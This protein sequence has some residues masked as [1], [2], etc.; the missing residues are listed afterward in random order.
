MMRTYQ[1]QLGI[2]KHIIIV[3]SPNVQTNFKIQLFNENKL[4]LIN[5][6]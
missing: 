4:E 1:K 5:G 3:A 2:N 6:L